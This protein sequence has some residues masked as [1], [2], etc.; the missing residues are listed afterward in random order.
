MPIEI[1]SRPISPNGSVADHMTRALDRGPGAVRMHLRQDPGEL[2]PAH[3][4]QQVATAQ[5]LLQALG[6]LAQSA[7]PRGMTMEVVDRL[8]PIEVEDRHRQ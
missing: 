7:I 6:D 4:R 1:V 2:L 8:E 3:A 5:N